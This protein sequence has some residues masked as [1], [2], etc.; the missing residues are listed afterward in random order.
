MKLARNLFSIGIVCAM[1]SLSALS[2]AQT[3]TKDFVTVK[4]EQIVWKDGDLGVKSTVL[5]GDPTKPGLYIVRNIFPAGIMS[6]PHSHDQDRYV[7]VIRG[8]WNAGTSPSWDPAS[9]TALPT[10]SVMFHPAGAVHFDGSIKEETE[11]QIMGMGPVSTKS[12]YPELGRFGNA[13]KMN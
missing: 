11:V 3:T 1:S 5:F 13:R 9:T 7:T 4:R 10:G 6:T 12:V 8:T 2:H